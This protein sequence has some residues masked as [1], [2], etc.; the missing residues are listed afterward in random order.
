MHDFFFINKAV[1]LNNKDSYIIDFTYK[2]NPSVWIWAAEFGYQ[3]SML[4]GEAAAVNAALAAHHTAV[5]GSA[6]LKMRANENSAS[7]QCD[8]WTYY[9]DG[10]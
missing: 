7:L 2:M 6:S 10:T 8:S 4:E 1:E 5:D 3:A 9:K